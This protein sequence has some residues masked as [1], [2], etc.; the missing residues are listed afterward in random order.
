MLSHLLHSLLTIVLFICA[1]IF[2][3]NI[4]K[5]KK[6]S[7]HYYFVHDKKKYFWNPILVCRL[8]FEP[9]PRGSSQWA[10]LSIIN[11]ISF[12]NIFYGDDGDGD[13]DG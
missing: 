3:V 2:S 8:F 5:Q 10:L 11:T 1:L 13:G 9:S 4:I 6:S 7:A 12:S